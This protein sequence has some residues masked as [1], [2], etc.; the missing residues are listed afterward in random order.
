MIL[1][2]ALLLLATPAAAQY[3]III[4]GTGP[5]PTVSA[6][7]TPTPVPVPP[8]LPPPVVVPPPPVDATPFVFPTDC[9]RYA[10]RGDQDRYVA[11]GEIGGDYG[12]FYVSGDDAGNP[13]LNSD[14][15]MGLVQ[16]GVYAGL[17]LWGPRRAGLSHPGL[18]RC[19]LVAAKP[20]PP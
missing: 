6:G 8:P 14:V 7:P 19:L 9:P 5:P 12:T 4:E 11:V 16:T 20:C 13:S 15:C 17:R 3:R 2:L 1:L 10:Y 18:I